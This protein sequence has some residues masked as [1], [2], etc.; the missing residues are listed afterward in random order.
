MNRNINGNNNSSCKLKFKTKIKCEIYLWNPYQKK[1]SL[2]RKR[3]LKHIHM[4]LKDI[5][6]NFL[7]I[8]STSSINLVIRFRQLFYVNKPKQ[9]KENEST[10]S[11]IFASF[12]WHHRLNSQSA[13]IRWRKHWNKIKIKT[14]M[15]LKKK[16]SNLNSNI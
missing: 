16:I 13:F 3:I 4:V 1:K 14:V 15:C 2:N 11:L 10:E 9:H 12:W 6:T 7:F 8:H 5:P